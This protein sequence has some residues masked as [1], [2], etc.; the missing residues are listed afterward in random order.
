MQRLFFLVALAAF[1]LFSTSSMNA[2]SSASL[3]QRQQSIATISAL[4]AQG[5]LPKLHDA[6]SQGLDNGLTIN[7]E[8]EVLAQLYAYCGFP[9]SLNGI[10]TLMKVVDERKAQGKHDAV[11]KE[12]TPVTSTKSK[13]ERGKKNL[14]TLTGKPQDKLSG[15]NAFCPEIDVFLKEHL[16]ADIFERDVLTFQE[17]ELATVS[18]LA[19]MPGVEPMLQAHLGMS[20]NTG[21]TEAQLRQ[22]LALQE[23][24]V[25]K[26]QAETSR[27]VLRKALAD[28][29]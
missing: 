10:N 22:V 5:N 6:L 15:A 29:K 13:Y 2:Q 17:R 24:L 14:E 20:M 26:K 25:D 11:G 9:R 23:P 18:A 7:E 8:K 1:F 28:K 21:L 19:A 27:E 3:D 12:A 4:T 16:F